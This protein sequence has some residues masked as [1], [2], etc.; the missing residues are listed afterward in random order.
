MISH[1]TWQQ[2][3]EQS[4]KNT[5]V[6]FCILPVQRCVTLSAAGVILSAFR[7][8]RYLL[9][10]KEVLKYTPVVHSDYKALKVC[11]S[12]CV[13]LRCLT[14]TERTHDCSH[15]LRRYEYER[16]Q[17]RASLRN[18]DAQL[19]PSLIHYCS[20][21]QAVAIA[22]PISPQRSSHAD[23]ATVSGQTPRGAV[24]PS[25]PTK[26]SSWISARVVPSSSGTPVA[27]ST[28]PAQSNSD[29]TGMTSA[30]SPRQRGEN[31]E[32][33]S[34][35]ADALAKLQPL[36]LTLLPTPA[37]PPARPFSTELRV[38]CP[39]TMFCWCCFVNLSTQREP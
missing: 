19:Y 30:T 21:E 10:L 18:T 15:D 27:T 4:L 31:D 32:V 9:L 26:S 20:F 24:R 36:S 11:L 13:Y 16:S 3:E 34:S 17:V 8:P 37:A 33:R 29:R 38:L 25:S 14:L 5:V 2:C 23:P 1:V 39:I 22:R 12:L 7:P 6:S 28:T 35:R